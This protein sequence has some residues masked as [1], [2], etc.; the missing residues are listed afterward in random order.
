MWSG[1]AAQRVP[2]YMPTIIFVPMSVSYRLLN[3][4]KKHLYLFLRTLKI[5]FLST[6]KNAPSV[7]FLSLRSFFVPR[8]TPI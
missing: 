2:P 6:P 1:A 5:F 4:K 8:P 7:L 3:E